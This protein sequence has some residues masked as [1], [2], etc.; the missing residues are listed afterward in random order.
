MYVI[1]VLEDKLAIVPEQFGR[2]PT[3]VLIEEIEKKYSNKVVLDVGLCVMF[4]DFVEVGVPY[5]YP[6]EGS[7]HQLVK[8]RMVV[9]RPWEGEVLTGTICDADGNGMTI[10]MGFFNN[11]HIDRNQLPTPCSFN[12]TS[13]S[14]MWHYNDEEGESSTDYPLV[15]GDNVRFKVLNCIFPALIKG[16]TRERL[17]AG[18]GDAE[19]GPAMKILASMDSSTPALGAI[20]WWRD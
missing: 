8:F 16:K 13:K 15:V 1:C 12:P 9:F 14:Y 19:E 10:S 7:A 6:A 18:L 4:Y 11:I 20:S 3:D 17:Q 5:V 2:D